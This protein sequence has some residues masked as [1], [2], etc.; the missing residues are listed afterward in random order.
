MLPVLL[1]EHSVEVMQ[2]EFWRRLARAILADQSIG[3]AH[4]NQMAGHPFRQ[5]NRKNSR[6]PLFG[7][8]RD[9]VVG[10]ANEEFGASGHLKKS[11]V[12]VTPRPIGCGA[13]DF[14]NVATGYGFAKKNRRFR[15][16]VFV[17]SG[18]RLSNCRSCWATRAFEIIAF[19]AKVSRKRHAW[20]GFRRRRPAVHYIL[21]TRWPQG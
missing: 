10:A 8:S 2:F 12:L 9:V 7:K 21:M 17:F 4:F 13:C 3:R 20:P 5:G 6:V 14:N 18:S 11:P 16:F 19:L 15:L 1:S